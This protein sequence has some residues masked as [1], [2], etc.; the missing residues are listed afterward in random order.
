LDAI[1]GTSGFGGG[2]GGGGRI[3]IQVASGGFTNNGTVD[4]SGGSSLG[5]AVGGDGVFTAPASVSSVP[6]PSSVV[7][8]AL[9][10][11]GLLGYGWRRRN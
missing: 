8:L 11:L 2:S 5:A 10:S 4:V 7:L 3:L 6:E 1:G 9:G